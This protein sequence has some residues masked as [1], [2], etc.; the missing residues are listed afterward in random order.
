V[1]EIH[2]MVVTCLKQLQYFFHVTVWYEKSSC[3]IPNAELDYCHL[4]KK[5]LYIIATCLEITLMAPLCVT[6]RDKVPLRLLKLYFNRVDLAKGGGTKWFVIMQGLVHCINSA[7]YPQGN[8][9]IRKSYLLTVIGGTM[10]WTSFLKI[11][12]HR[13]DLNSQS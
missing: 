9:K 6:V 13:Q 12:R 3:T 10:C 5:C 7:K 8:N 2:C 4:N 1:S 11:Y